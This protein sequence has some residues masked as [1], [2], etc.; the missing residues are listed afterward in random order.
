MEHDLGRA[1]DRARWGLIVKQRLPDGRTR[2]QPL[3]DSAT[4]E[5][6]SFAS[7]AEARAAAARLTSGPDAEFRAMPL[8]AGEGDPKAGAHRAR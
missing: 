6:V 4:G 8:R 3:R 7:E 1:N 2:L 5:P